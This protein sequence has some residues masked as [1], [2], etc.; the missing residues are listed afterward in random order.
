MVA[1][2]VGADEVLYLDLGSVVVL[3]LIVVFDSDFDLDFD[4]DFDSDFDFGTLV[5]DG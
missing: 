1:K 4:F 5:E 3:V 2:V